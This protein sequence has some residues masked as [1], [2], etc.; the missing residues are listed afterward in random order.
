[1]VEATIAENWATNYTSIDLNTNATTDIVDTSRQTKVYS[2]HMLNG[3]S[4]AV[5]QL[6]VT[7]GSSTGVLTQG[8]SAGDT[9]SFTGPIVVPSGETVQ[10]NVTTVEGAAQ[11]NTCLVTRGNQAKSPSG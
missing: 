6:E 3:G 9:I 4:S 8:Q 2:V 1:M 5:A 10:I 11:S 7:D